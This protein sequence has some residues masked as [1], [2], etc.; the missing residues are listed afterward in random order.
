M[1][2][3]KIM[4]TKTAGLS[5]SMNGLETKSFKAVMD[6]KRT[7]TE[8]PNLTLTPANIPTEP[9]NLTSMVNDVVKNHELST[10]TMQTFMARTDYNP[11]RLLAIQYKTGVLFLREQMYCKTAELSANTFKNFTQMQI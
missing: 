3:D 10:K 8:L 1:T 11:E 2:I 5:S 9:V 7:V 6:Q 4:A